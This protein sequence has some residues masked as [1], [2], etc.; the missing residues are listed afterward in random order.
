[1]E[2]PGTVGLQIGTSCY[3]NE[4]RFHNLAVQL[5]PPGATLCRSDG[6]ADNYGQGNVLTG[7]PGHGPGTAT[8]PHRTAARPDPLK[9]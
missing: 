8:L 7:R 6:S 3:F 9:C 5:A 2:G 1:M 4:R